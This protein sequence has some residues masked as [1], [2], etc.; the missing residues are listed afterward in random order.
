MTESQ[1]AEM[2]KDMIRDCHE[3]AEAVHPDGDTSYGSML[4]EV[5]RLACT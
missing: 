3:E 2:V 1:A 4:I 5:I